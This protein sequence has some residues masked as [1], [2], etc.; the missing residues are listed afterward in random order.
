MQEAVPLADELGF[1]GVLI[2]DHYMWQRSGEGE[3]GG[4]TTLESW[5]ALTY[6]AAITKRL[7]LGTLVTPIPFRPPAM[8][9]KIVS[10]LDVL[11]NGRTILGVGAGWSQT[12]FDGYSEWND[13]KTRVDK[14]KEGLRLILRLWQEDKVDFDGRFYKAKGAVLDP[15]PIQKPHP[16]LIFGSSGR[17]MMR[18]AG[19][20]ADICFLPRWFQMPFEE[21]KAIVEGEAR[22]AGRQGRIAYAKG[23]PVYREKEFDMKNLEQD[24]ERAADQGCRYYITPFPETDYVTNMSRFAKDVMTSYA[25]L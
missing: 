6:L 25:E 1:W 15:K 24:V 2:P 12:E 11:S 19:K 22:K 9:A 5:I 7:K 14:T 8:V 18:L 4:N 20:H 17:R 21:A 16:P 23:S 13:A 3:H 10:T